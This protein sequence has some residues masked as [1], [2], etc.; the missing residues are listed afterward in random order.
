MR[1]AIG[2]VRGLG[3]AGE[4]VGHWKNQRLTG[5]ANVILIVW[6]VFQAVG[7]TNAT[8]LDWL[9]WFA[10]PIHAT[11]MVLLVMSGFWHAALGVQVVIEDYIHCEALKVASLTALALVSFALAAAGVVSILMLATGGA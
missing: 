9:E 10:S 4:G 6:F 7:M 8:R 3:S 11:G 5:V 1:S 2:Q